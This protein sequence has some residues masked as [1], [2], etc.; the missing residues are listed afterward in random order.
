MNQTNTGMLAIFV[1]LGVML[2]AGLIAIPT[3]EQA[4]LANKGGTSNENAEPIRSCKSPNVSKDN[5]D[6]GLTR[7]KEKIS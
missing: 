6:N 7:C 2:I 3:I 4:A 1:A 5:N